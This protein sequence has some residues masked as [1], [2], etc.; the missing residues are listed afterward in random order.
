M[1]FNQASCMQ[2]DI[3]VTMAQRIMWLESA[4]G[5]YRPSDIR[6]SAKLVS[7]FEDRWCH[8]VSVTDPHGRILAFLDRSRHFFFPVAPQS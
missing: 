5:L 4:C 7:T 6:M 2:W 1:Y 8:V 3:L